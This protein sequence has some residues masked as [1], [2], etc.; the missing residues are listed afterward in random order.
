R[1]AARGAGGEERK[2]R[3]GL[4]LLLTLPGT[5][6]LYQGDEIALENGEVP[7]DGILDV[8]SPPRDPA[9]T[10]MPWTRGGREWRE[11]WLPLAN[12]GRNVE[13]QRADPGSTLHY[14]R[15]LI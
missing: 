15:D 10:P 4:F 6:I 14:V 3:A 2:A 1:L 13:Q 8:A 12:T 9:G 7:A 5:A 11:P